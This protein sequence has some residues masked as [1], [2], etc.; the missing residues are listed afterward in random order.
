MYILFIGRVYVGDN[1]RKS[2]MYSK[3]FDDLCG[4]KH[5]HRLLTPAVIL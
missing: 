5:F 4:K 3:D 1:G 2:A